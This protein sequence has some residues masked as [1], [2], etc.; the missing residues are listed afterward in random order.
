MIEPNEQS[1][2]DKLGEQPLN[3]AS[4]ETPV[5]RPRRRWFQ[6]GLSTLLAV[7][8]L[9][10]GG[11]MAWRVYVEPYRHQRQTMALVE[12]L[13]GSYRTAAA[14][15]WVRWALGADYQNI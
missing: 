12:S 6:F 14:D 7:T 3:A 8:A 2:P 5:K 11:A 15:T 4:R 1:S 10:A 9:A 13:H